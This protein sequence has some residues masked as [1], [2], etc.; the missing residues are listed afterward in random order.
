MEGVPPCPVVDRVRQV[1]AR[2]PADP[3]VVGGGERITYRDLLRQTDQWQSR[4]ADLCLAPGTVVA[5]LAGGD[6]A[7]PAAFLGARAA[8]LVPLLVDEQQPADRVT[9]VLDTARPSAV[10]R[11][12][13]GEAEPTG[14]PDP[15][16]L[17]AGAGYLVFSSGSQGTPKG[18]VGRAAGLLAF[19]DWEIAA[20][21]LGPGTRVAM[22]TS[23]SFDV[24]YRDLL[25]PLCSGGELHIAAPAVRATPA[26]VLPWL[27]GN[28]IEVLHAVPSLSAR[29]LAA[30]PPTTPAPDALRH[31]VFAGEPLYGRHVRAW[32]AAAPKSKVANL[33]GPSE[34][35]LAKFHYDVPGDCGPGLQ[36]VGHPLPGAVLGLEPADTG[37]DAGAD[38]SDSPAGGPA[39]VQR[40]VVTTPDG[41]LGYL[42][43]TCGPDDR[44]RLTCTGGTTEFRT[45]DRGVLDE[46]G[47]L[48]VLG[49]LDSLVKRRGVFV[50]IASVEAAAAG[51]PAVRSA[52]C[53]QL[54]SSGDLVLVVEGP[55]PAV[56]AALRRPLHAVLGAAMPDRV[57][58]LAAMPLLPGGKADRRGL[59][60][61][62]DP[63]EAGDDRRAS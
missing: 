46:A 56:A 19:I 52:C 20:L 40:V 48:V 11:P 14:E 29:W 13:T 60:E 28:G 1:A 50:D 49:R 17:P 44:A 18:I 33:Y 7:W 10:L 35:T 63:E 58:A 53:V 37:A 23:P 6:P 15:R 9:D 4:C 22:L 62:L 38:R 39:G 5:V 32:R 8:G 2:H 21:G 36:P 31:T 51:L 42:P 54:P 47:R 25:L 12:E 41:S 34:T 30:A 3:A 27:A 59:R 57:V 24:V 61:L 16:V 45:Q 43:D 55:D 26:A